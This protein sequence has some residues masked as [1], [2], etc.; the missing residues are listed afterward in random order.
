ME[1]AYPAVVTPAGAVHQTFTAR[2][3]LGEKSIHG[4]VVILADSRARHVPL[5]LTCIWAK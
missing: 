5:S 4:R 3:F 2:T 1:A